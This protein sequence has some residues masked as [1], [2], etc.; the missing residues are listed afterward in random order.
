MA[1]LVEVI[2]R[3]EMFA[4]LQKEKKEFTRGAILR[5]IVIIFFSNM[6]KHRDVR[7]SFYSNLG[8]ELLHFA[9][10]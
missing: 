6:F 3:E 4:N 10:A 2:P 7:V 9:G 8:S 1:K 5:Y